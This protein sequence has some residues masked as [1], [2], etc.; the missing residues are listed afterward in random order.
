[1]Q[2][3][4]NGLGGVTAYL[5][6]GHLISLLCRQLPLQGEA[7]GSDG[8]AGSKFKGKGPEGT[9]AGPG[10]AGDV[11][12]KGGEGMR[13]DAGAGAGEDALFRMEEQR[14]DRVASGDVVD[15]LPGKAGFLRARQLTCGEA[16][17]V[18]D[19]SAG[20]RCGAGRKGVEGVVRAFGMAGEN[21]AGLWKTAGKSGDFGILD[22]AMEGRE[23]IIE[24]VHAGGNAAAARFRTAEEEMKAFVGS[25]QHEIDQA[26]GGIAV[27][28]LEEDEG[29]KVRVGADDLEGFKVGWGKFSAGKGGGLVE[30]SEAGRDFGKGLAGG[31]R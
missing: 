2:N 23:E 29:G 17:T 8:E 21:G 7:L 11:K 14:A 18:E 31:D 22:G 12:L 26:G 16:L 6:G 27:G 13:M 9:Q 3:R 25:A 30:G 24:P 15:G 10:S 28:I 5:N 20:V 19:D 1:M 4:V